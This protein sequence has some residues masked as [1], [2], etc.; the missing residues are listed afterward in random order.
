MRT[1]LVAF[2]ALLAI[3]ACFAAEDPTE[4]LEGVHDLSEHI[5]AIARK[6]RLC[7]RAWPDT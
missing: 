4:A 7:S 1:S 3:G 5:P 2:S 6:A